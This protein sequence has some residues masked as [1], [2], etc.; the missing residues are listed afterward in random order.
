MSLPL[1]PGL[2]DQDVAAV[3]EAVLDVVQTYRR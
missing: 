2:S 3:V 1:H